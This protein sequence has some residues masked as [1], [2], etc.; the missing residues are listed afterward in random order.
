MLSL[1]K[2]SHKKCLLNRK[3]TTLPL[4]R[5]IDQDLRY[6]KRNVR[7]RTVIIGIDNE[8]YSRDLLLETYILMSLRVCS[9]G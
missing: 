1:Q 9:G 6:K 2:K 8:I 4:R 3:E 7:E 5:R